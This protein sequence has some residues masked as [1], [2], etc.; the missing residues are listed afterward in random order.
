MHLLLPGGL[1]NPGKWAKG[2]HLMV[3]VSS[4][5]LEVR[6]FSAQSE[7]EPPWS[8]RERIKQKTMDSEYKKEL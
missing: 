6:Y 2:L 4:V 1:A 7:G 3:S 5:T 8:W